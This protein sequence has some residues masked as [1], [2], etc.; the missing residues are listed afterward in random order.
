MHTLKVPL[1]VSPAP[2]SSPSTSSP[3]TPRL[4]SVGSTTGA[5]PTVAQAANIGSASGSSSGQRDLGSGDCPVFFI[6]RPGVS[7]QRL[8]HR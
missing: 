6:H 3:E 4:E 2:A 1:T 8:E 5:P 7:A